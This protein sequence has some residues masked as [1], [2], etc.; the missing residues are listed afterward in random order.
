MA[1]LVIIGLIALVVL[2]VGASVVL[3]QDTTQATPGT[4]V[5]PIC[6]NAGANVEQMQQMHDAMGQNVPEGMQQTHDAM[7]QAL[8]SGDT[9]QIQ[10]IQSTCRSQHGLQN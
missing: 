5:A 9:A 6:P 7:T 10:Q 1:K 8:Q 2:L 4:A 3:A